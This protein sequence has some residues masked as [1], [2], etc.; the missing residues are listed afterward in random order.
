MKQQGVKGTRKAIWEYSMRNKYHHQI[1]YHE[2]DLVSL[3]PEVP[4]V[5]TENGVY[6]VVKRYGDHGDEILL[7]ELRYLGPFLNANRWL[8]IARKR[9]R[10]RIT[11]RM[12]PNDPR[13]V[14][15]QDPDAGLQYFTLATEDAL[16]GRIATVYDLVETHTSE[17][18]QKRET[19]DEADRA[20]ARM[21][22][23][24]NADRAEIKKAKKKLKKNQ[25]KPKQQGRTGAGR[26]KN[27]QDEVAATG[28]APIPIIVS[29]TIPAVITRPQGSRPIAEGGTDASPVANDETSNL[30]DQWLNGEAL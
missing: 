24:N 26:R 28:Q 27:Q 4:A 11:I 25:T 10:W 9:G 3:C 18:G 22:Q 1:A 19:K 29:T 6:P 2:D 15:Y 12:N 17:I 23:E 20:A 14:S 5:V 13:R 8:E 7:N 16:L 21:Y 30:I